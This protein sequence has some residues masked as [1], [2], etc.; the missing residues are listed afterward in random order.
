MR[1]RRRGR[2]IERGDE[3]EGSERQRERETAGKV[4][5]WIAEID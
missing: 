1:E 5:C 2:K 3:T 4:R